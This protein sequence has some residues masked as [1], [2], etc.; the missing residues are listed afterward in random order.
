MDNKDKYIVDIG[1]EPGTG[2][3]WNVTATHRD[4]SVEKAV[5]TGRRAPELAMAYVEAVDFFEKRPPTE[6]PKHVIRGGVQHIALDKEHEEKLGPVTDA[7]RAH[8]EALKKQREEHQKRHEDT[9]AARQRMAAQPQANP[10]PVRIPEGEDD[11]NYSE[12]VARWQ[13]ERR[14]ENPGTNKAK[15]P[16]EPVQ[17]DGAPVAVKA[18]AAVETDSVKFP[19]PEAI[20]AGET[21]KG[22][23]NVRPPDGVHSA[24]SAEPKIVDKDNKN[25]DPKHRP[26]I[27][28]EPASLPA[29]SDEGEG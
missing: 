8:E 18:N 14:G 25:T 27:N 15:P 13:D 21:F 28:Q 16:L 1:E 24:P 23:D 7:D 22:V 17:V 12:R 10:K 3:A 29:Y 2:G 6:Y 5:F 9:E 26:M 20:R 19:T 11:M 4:G